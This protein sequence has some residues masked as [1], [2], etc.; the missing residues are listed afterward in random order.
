LP[1]QISVIKHG[2]G[3]FNGSL[4]NLGPAG[5]KPADNRR[6]GSDLKYKLADALKRALPGFFSRHPPMPGFQNKMKRKLKRGNPETVT[7]VK[8][9]PSGVR[10]TA[11]PDETNPGCLSGVF[12]ENL[13]VLDRRGALK[14]CRC[15]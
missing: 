12:N 13:L 6:E 8:E 4:N 7:G 2:K 11:L 1:L 14:G 10:I 15:L 5:E 3:V 9:T